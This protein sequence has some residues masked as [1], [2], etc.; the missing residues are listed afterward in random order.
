MRLRLAATALQAWILAAGFSP[1][2]AAEVQVS[3]VVVSLTPAAR[4][5]IIV[6]R[7]QGRTTARFEL[8]ARAWEQGP[9]GEM[10]LGPTDGIAVFPP[11]LTVAPGEERNVRVGA[12]SPFGPVETTFRL[13][14]DEMPAPESPDSPSQ[15]RVVTRLS[16]PVFLAPAKPV[17]KT[18]VA[19]LAVSAGT[20]SFRLV[21]EGTVHVLPTAVKLVGLD[22][23]GKSVFEKDLPAW[24]V[25][26]GGRREYE[27]PVPRDACAS[28]RELEVTATLPREV[29]RARLAAQAPCAP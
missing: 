29:V 10:V 27:V 1:A 9:T 7:N 5:A 15:V 13:L 3:P 17:E 8:Q 19:G 28:I 4:S 11:V 12:T 14:M 25:L 20:A 23:A 21:N 24:Y 6:V 18:A 16:L 26:A 22:A 2:R